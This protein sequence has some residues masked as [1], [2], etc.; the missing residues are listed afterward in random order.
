M[1]G[2]AF[3]F[4]TIPTGFGQGGANLAPNGAQGS[5]DLE[6][7]INELRTQLARLASVAN[8]NGAS[9][10]GLKPI[11]GLAATELQA[12]IAELHADIDA[13]P[14]SAAL[15]AVTGATLI[16]SNAAGFIAATVAGQL[17]EGKALI[18]AGMPCLKKTVTVGHADLTDAVAG[19]AQAINVGTALPN[20]ARIVGAGIRGVPLTGGGV[21]SVACDLGTAGDIDAI[22]DGADVL[23]AFVDG[24]SST[25][26]SGIAPHKL[27]AAGGQLIATFTPDGGHALADL[28]A[29]SIDIDVLYVVLP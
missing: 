5:P 17:A 18:D 4:T 19:E 16:G 15:A 10:I 14:T 12:A 6:T 3:V 2:Q 8:N 22:V 23:A 27:F 1:A 20:N 25:L 7:V 11:V 26:P 9:M 21:V 28:A 13:A 24:Q 29:G